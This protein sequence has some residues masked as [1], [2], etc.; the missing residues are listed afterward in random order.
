MGEGFVAFLAFLDGVEI[1]ASDGSD[2]Q[3]RRWGWVLFVAEVLD[4]VEK[5]AGFVADFFEQLKV[6]IGEPCV[7]IALAILVAR[8]AGVEEVEKLFV[9]SHAAR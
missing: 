6:P 2:E 8:G 7:V 1:I 5:L 4:E 3:G 9:P